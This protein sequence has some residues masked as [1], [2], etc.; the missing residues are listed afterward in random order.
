MIDDQDRLVASLKNGEAGAFEELINSYQGL[1]YNICLNVMGQQQDAEDLTQE[2]F[3][4]LYR[5]I[6]RFE[7]KSKLS[8]WIYRI[9]KNKCMDELKSRKRQKRA[10]FFSFKKSIDDPKVINI[11]SNQF[12]PGVK[13]ENQE[14]AKILYSKIEELNPNQR[15]AFTLFFIEGR[16]YKEVAEIMELSVSAVESIIFRS[17]KKLRGLITDFLSKNDF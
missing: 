1:V 11:G 2:V 9:A 6:H 7:G 10:G 5:A 16:S 8:T 14:K 3:V 15:I 17:K 12:H 4:D 13:L